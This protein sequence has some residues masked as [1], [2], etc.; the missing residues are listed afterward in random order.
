[1]RA[2]AYQSK[3]YSNPELASFFNRDRVQGEAEKGDGVVTW[4]WMVLTWMLSVPF[5]ITA[6]TLV[7]RRLLW[8]LLLL[9]V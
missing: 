6:I 8:I 3:W 7:V 1:M 4:R 9:F 2:V 5:I